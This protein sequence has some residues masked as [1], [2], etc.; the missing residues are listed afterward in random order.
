MSDILFIKCKIC[1]K[2]CKTFGGLSSHIIKSHK[3]L[4]IE[5]YYNKYL[6]KDDLE[7]ICPECGHK[8]GFIRLSK[9]FHKYCSCICAGKDNNVLEKRKE[10]CLNKY[11]V[12]NTGKLPHALGAGLRAYYK[13]T[14]LINPAQDKNNIKKGRQ[15]YEYNN[16]M[17]DSS[18]ELCYFIWLK[19][20]NINFEYH[21]QVKFTYNYDGKE[22]YYFVDFCVNGIY[23]ELKSPQFFDKNGTFINPY[24]KNNSELYKAKYNCMIDNNVQIIKNCDIYI[25]YV[26][27]KY[28]KNFIKEHKRY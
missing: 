9:G 25:N 19:D 10:T 5:E 2:I 6:K 17:F 3:D 12:D 4:T 20:N 28:G 23:Q 8:T 27:K 1:Y 24:D 15:K 7:G 11:G 13:K 14:G 16:I 22:H 26:C 21:P 18:W